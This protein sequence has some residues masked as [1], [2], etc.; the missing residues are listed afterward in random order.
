MTTSGSSTTRTS[1]G[2]ATPP[3]RN[4][5]T[6]TLESLRLAALKSRAGKQQP[7]KVS[8]TL[9][10]AAAIAFERED[11]EISEDEEVESVVSEKKSRPS[12][13]ISVGS[14]TDGISAT[15]LSHTS[16]LDSSLQASAIAALAD[17]SRAGLTYQQVL[18]L[19]NIHPLFL[20]N[21]VSSISMPTPPIAEASKQSSLTAVAPP[22]PPPLRSSSPLPPS[23]SPPPTVQSLVDERQLESVAIEALVFLASL[24]MSYDDIVNFGGVHPHY[25]AGLVVHSPSTLLNRSQYVKAATQTIALSLKRSTE[26][27]SAA[28]ASN[29]NDAVPTTSFSTTGSAAVAAASQHSENVSRASSKGPLSTATSATSTPTLTSA[30]S[31]PPNAALIAATTAIQYNN[32][33]AV[34]RNTVMAS[35]VLKKRPTALD[36]DAPME[37]KG[38][39]GSDRFSGRMMIEMSDSDED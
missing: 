7:R 38:R 19:G 33:V 39:F 22:A 11:G 37:F 27:L 30:P 29:S 10:K 21:L 23:H 6:T 8:R 18:S 17:L 28:R 31:F 4:A 24:G 3:S 36:F 13:P 34:V 14:A 32:G 35:R 12:T 26:Q 15:G 1:T 25:L 20:S 16:M 9:S 5:P 2:L